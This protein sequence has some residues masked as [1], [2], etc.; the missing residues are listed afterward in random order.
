MPE[1]KPVRARMPLLL[2]C[3]S[4]S[5]KKKSSRPHRATGGGWKTSPRE[6]GLASALLCSQLPRTRGEAKPHLQTCLCHE[7]RS[8]GAT[9]GTWRH[10]GGGNPALAWRQGFGD[11]W[12]SATTCCRGTPVA[13]RPPRGCPSLAETPT[14]SHAEAAAA[15]FSSSATAPV[16]ELRR[17]PSCHRNA[18][19][20]R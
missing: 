4:E 17:A 7:A 5:L 12:G 11:E 13:T 3:R 2:C 16:P 8:G 1:A 18:R 19:S 15:S 20:W 10:C 9:G 6:H 14:V